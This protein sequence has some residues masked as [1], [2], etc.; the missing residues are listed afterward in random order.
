VLFRGVGQDLDDDHNPLLYSLLTASSKAY[1]AKPGD[2]KVR[3]QVTGHDITLVSA[4]QGRNNARAVFSGSLELFSNKFFSASSGNR[5]FAL[6]VTL[7]AFKQ[8]GVLRA[9][10]VRHHRVGETQAP[11]HYRIKDE[12][13]YHVDIHQ[14]D[15]DKKSWQPFVA[16]D[17]QL[18]FTRLDPHVRQALKHDNKGHFSLKFTVPDV[19]GIFTFRVDYQ[20]LGYTFI[21]LQVTTPVRPFG[22][23]EYERFLPAAY[24]YY[25]GA[26]SML[27]GL[28]VFAVF[29]LFTKE[30][31]KKK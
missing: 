4:F 12:V 11:A 26:F 18:E 15:A 27:A 30:S 17:V 6:D 1:S 8:R 19:Y 9:Q 22:H 21:D 3:H 10:N 16:D 23:D 7:W 14:W 5:A 20:R 24:P 31:A 29:F 28:F 13:E 25:T 2:T